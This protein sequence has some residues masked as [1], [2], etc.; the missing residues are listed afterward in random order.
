MPSQDSDAPTNKSNHFSVNYF[1]IW[2]YRSEMITLNLCL[3]IAAQ[4]FYRVRKLPKFFERR[5]GVWIFQ[6]SLQIE[7]EAITPRRSSNRAALDLEQVQITA[8]KC[9]QGLAQ[10]S[11]LVR[12]MQ[13]KRKLV[14][15]LRH[16]V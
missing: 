12:K 11:R 14:G 6:R 13:D 10:R 4:N 7:V 2:L 5:D 8:R 16:F 9:I 15:L 3:R 1:R